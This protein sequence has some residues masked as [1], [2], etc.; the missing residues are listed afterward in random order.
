MILDL[1]KS[2]PKSRSALPRC[3]HH[4][5]AGR[6]CSQ[7]V[8]S[9]SPHFCF[10]HKPD[11]DQ[12]LIAELTEAAGSL[13]TPEEIHNFLKKVTLLR[14]QGRLTPKESGNYTYLCQILQ[15]GLREIAFHQKL[16]AERAEHE[17]EQ[18]RINQV[19]SWSIP[20]PDRSGPSDDDVQPAP[21]ESATTA[22]ASP[23]ESPSPE[24]STPST[25]SQPVSHPDKNETSFVRAG[26]VHTESRSARPL[27]DVAHTAATVAESAAEKTT[28]P[29]KSN[30]TPKTAAPPPARSTK[31]AKPSE[32]STSLTSF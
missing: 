18:S 28:P 20:R 29:Q 13:S 22:T 19:M 1:F 21:A 4:S 17:A 32:S 26:L 11:P 14:V 10:T 2:E 15:R 25:T 5:P 23:S 6:Q 12:L 31:H 27:L 8:C 3:Q 9:T 30:Q 24:P 16:R 7:P